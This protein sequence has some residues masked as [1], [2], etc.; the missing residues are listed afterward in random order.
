MQRVSGARIKV[1]DRGEFLPNTTNR[2]V[3]I[4]GTKQACGTAHFLISQR[5]AS[6]VVRPIGDHVG[7]FSGREG[8]SGQQQ[9]TRKQQQQ[10]GSRDDDF[11]EDSHDGDAHDGDE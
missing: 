3:V 5:M 7:E 6:Q 11:E 4:S 10:Y 2:I 8:R 1:S 9:R